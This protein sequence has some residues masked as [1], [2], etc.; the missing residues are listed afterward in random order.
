MAEENR[1]EELDLDPVR[2][3]LR[4]RGVN[5]EVLIEILLDPQNIDTIL[6]LYVKDEEWKKKL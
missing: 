6:N 3:W 1:I 4:N 5:D 2:R